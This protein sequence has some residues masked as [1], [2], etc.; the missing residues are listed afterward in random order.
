[1]NAN[2]FEAIQLLRAANNSE[3]FKRDLILNLSS[4]KEKF[5]IYY[6]EHVNSEDLLNVFFVHEKH[7]FYCLQKVSKGEKHQI[8]ISEIKWEISISNGELMPQQGEGR[9][10]NCLVKD[11]R[12]GKK[13]FQFK[14]LNLEP[15]TQTK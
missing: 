6:R 8:L 14:I 5:P 13:F 3:R 7:F 11:I 12:I 9:R 15:K 2:C 4:G 1:M 10:I